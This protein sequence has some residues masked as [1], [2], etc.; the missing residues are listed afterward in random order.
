MEVLGQIG[1]RNHGKE[2]ALL[3]HD[4]KL[5]LLG[6]GQNFVGLLQCNAGLSGDKVLVHDVR[7]WLLK[8]VLELDVTVGDDTK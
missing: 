1:A 7:Y 8:V 6:L 4:R 3:V 2:V 5:A